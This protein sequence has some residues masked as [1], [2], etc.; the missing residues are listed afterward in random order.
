MGV[1]VVS[2]TPGSED[3]GA[4]VT[5]LDVVVV[6]TVAGEVDASTFTAV[7]SLLR[8]HAATVGAASITTA[9]AAHTSRVIGPV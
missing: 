2:M 8:A 6:A 7:P 1:R 9:A 3:S 5:V 4:S